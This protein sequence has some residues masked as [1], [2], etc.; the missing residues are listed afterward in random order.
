MSNYNR[1]EAIA[2]LERVPGVAVID[3]VR[4]DRD[5]GEHVFLDVIVVSRSARPGN[6]TWGKID[7]LTGSQ[8]FD[9]VRT[10]PK[11]FV[12][13]IRAI[14]QAFFRPVKKHKPLR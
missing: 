13:T 8:G 5:K 7:Y 1:G 3:K 9:L 12:D 6:K 10:E 14:K 11:E 2:S 4:Y